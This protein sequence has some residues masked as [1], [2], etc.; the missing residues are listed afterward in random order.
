MSDEPR[1]VVAAAFTN[2]HEAH[3]AR[4]VLEAAGIEATIADEHL[5]SMTWTYSNAVGGVKSPG[6]RRSAGRGQ[7]CAGVGRHRRSAP[8]DRGR[9]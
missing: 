7:V 6:A 4:S 1:L 5:V 9:R 3:L 8:A 2:V